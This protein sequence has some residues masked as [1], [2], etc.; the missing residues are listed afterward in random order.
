[1]TVLMVYS[2]Y[3]LSASFLHLIAMSSFNLVIW[4]SNMMR[5][6]IKRISRSTDCLY[7]LVPECFLTIIEWN[8]MTLHI[9]IL[10]NVMMSLEVHQQV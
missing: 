9:V 8:W 7:P 3:R 10:S 6:R 4:Y 1:M 2:I 5:K